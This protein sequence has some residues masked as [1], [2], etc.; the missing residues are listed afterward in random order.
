ML[1]YTVYINSN[2][3][4]PLKLFSLDCILA[5]LQLEKISI[6]RYIKYIKPD[7]V[8]QSKSW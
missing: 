2:N 6:C 8:D 3:V 5:H 7:I 1:M 4:I